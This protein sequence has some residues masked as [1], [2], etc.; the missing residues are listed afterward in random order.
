MEN[1]VIEYFDLIY[2][3][4]GSIIMFLILVGFMALYTR[5]YLRRMREEEEEKLTLK[6]NHEKELLA[7]SL[8]I[9]ER[10]RTRIAA[11]L[12]DHLVGQIRVVQLISENKEVKSKLK[13]V[14]GDARRLSHD[15]SPPFLEKENIEHLISDYIYPFRKL[16]KIDVYLDV[17]TNFNFDTKEKLHLFRIFQEVFM[18]I[19]KHAKTDSIFIQ[20]RKTDASLSFMVKDFGVGF[21]ESSSNLGMKNIAIRARQLGATYQLKSKPNVGTRFTLNL[22][23]KNYGGH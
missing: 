4:F 23:I 6:L 19:D 9:Q 18:N 12:H 17:R 16:Y 21:K 8:D 7:Q 3:I 22:K 1:E 11:E 15:L 13:S 2:V 10:E 20:V 14:I 5:L